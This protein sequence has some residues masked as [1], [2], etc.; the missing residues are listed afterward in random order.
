MAKHNGIRYRAGFCA[1]YCFSNHGAML[2][3]LAKEFPR[4]FSSDCCESLTFFFFLSDFVHMQ[5]TEKYKFIV[6]LLM[7]NELLKWYWK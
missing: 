3:N 7:N 1:L 4:H 2:S 6:P 5:D